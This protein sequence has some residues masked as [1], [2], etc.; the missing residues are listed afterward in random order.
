M[1]D[2]HTL[3]G[4]GKSCPW[5][6]FE[7]HSV[8]RINNNI[9]YMSSVTRKELWLLRYDICDTERFET[10]NS[11]IKSRNRF[12]TFGTHPPTRIAARP[13]PRL[14]N[15]AAPETQEGWARHLFGFWTCCRSDPGCSAQQNKIPLRLGGGALP[16][17]TR[18][19][20]GRNGVGVYEAKL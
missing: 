9:R 18:R 11:P 14:H 20:R 19:E 1:Q 17:R 15:T 6:I 8:Y 2:V 7:L 12:L 10:R 16:V 4:K 3:H 5:S 13:L